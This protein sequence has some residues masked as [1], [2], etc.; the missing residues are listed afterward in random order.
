M[1]VMRYATN[2]GLDDE[3]VRYIANQRQWVRLYGIKVALVN[4]PKCPLPVAMR[5]MP[6]LNILAT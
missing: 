5:F 1:E 2:R 6:H 4:N 3:I